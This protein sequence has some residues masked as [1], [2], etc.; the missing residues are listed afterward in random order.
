MAT[1]TNSP[2]TATT[3]RKTSRVDALRASVPS[4][5]RAEHMPSHLRHAESDSL[6]N[7]RGQKLS[8]V[9]LFP[10]A[11]SGTVRGVVLFL[12]GIN[13]HC[14]RYYHLYEQLCEA[15][16][17]VL[18]YDLLSHGQSDSCEH[19]ARAHARKFHY[20]VDDTNDVL[21]FAKKELLPHFLGPAQPSPPLILAGMSYGTLV[22]LHTV[23]DEQHTFDAVVLVAPAVSVEWTTT[24][25]VQRVFAKPL[26]ALLPKARI[27]PGVNREWICRDP[28]FMADFESDPLNVTGD[29]TSR[30]GEQSLGAML[31]L[32]KD[33][34]V[35][36]PD[37]TFCA[38]P[39]LIMMGS[40]D[41]VTSLPLAKE[42]FARIATRDKE[43][44]VFE[45]PYHA[46]FDDPEKD[47]VFDYLVAWLHARFPQAAIASDAAA[48][49]SESAAADPAVEVDPKPEESSSETV[50]ATEA[51][52]GAAAITVVTTVEVKNE[53][54][55]ADASVVAA[56]STGDSV[57]TTASVTTSGEQ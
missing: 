53:V 19:G 13:E 29:M 50:T 20:F 49:A 40:N 36:Q 39:L 47:L 9:A 57:A 52:E 2:A 25:R 6:R 41:K 28:D 46:L 44:K 33:T 12:H 10:P 23:L 18:A 7:R 35:E 31:A 8:Y 37:S 27:V 16:F 14:R 34:R 4:S 32:K 24:L 55:E 56:A 42:F 38:V 45:G 43:L 54:V 26:S 11:E 17:G 51:V 15:G 5:W 1:T 3:V 48:V 21:A 30:M 22:S